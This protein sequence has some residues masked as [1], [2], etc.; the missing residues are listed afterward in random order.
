MENQ[1]LSMLRRREYV[2]TSNVIF[3][4]HLVY[5][6]VWKYKSWLFYTHISVTILEYENIK[7]LST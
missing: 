2:Q 7:L 4:I 6:Q 1:M 5:M 3:G